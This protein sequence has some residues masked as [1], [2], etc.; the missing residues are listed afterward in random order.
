MSILPI[1]S[2][3]KEIRAHIFFCSNMP[4]IRMQTER[5]DMI[6]DTMRKSMDIC[7]ISPI[8]SIWTINMSDEI[9]R[10]PQFRMPGARGFEIITE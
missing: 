10:E 1:I 4:K 2:S 6:S 7:T 9:H 3:V 5:C 8:R